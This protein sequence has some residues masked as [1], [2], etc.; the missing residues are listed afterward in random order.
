[1]GIHQ[2]VVEDKEVRR[3]GI[4]LSVS[5]IAIILRSSIISLTFISGD[6]GS[7][8]VHF[9]N[10]YGEYLD[11]MCMMKAWR[12][13]H[14][15]QPQCKMGLESLTL[16]G[17]VV[18]AQPFV[19]IFDE[20]KFKKLEFVGLNMDAG[21]ALK[22][23]MMIGMKMIVPD[24]NKQPQ[25]RQMATFYPAGSAKLITIGRGKKKSDGK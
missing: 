23:G 20:R 14:P 24:E 19:K 18:D 6:R 8:K 12:A 11:I 15:D 13:T 2:G 17:F 25:V 10:G 4:D 22:P 16:E 3:G 21:L 5:D 9:N 1:V 7:G